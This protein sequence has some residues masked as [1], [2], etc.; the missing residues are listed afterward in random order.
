[1]L[2]VGIESVGMFLHNII[3]PVQLLLF[4]NDIEIWFRLCLVQ[5]MFGSIDDLLIHRVAFMPK[6][7]S[8]I[9]F[10]DVIT[11]LNSKKY[12]KFKFKIQK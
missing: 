11:S 6:T 10:C 4:T 5:V 12:L 3:R 2:Y 1:M 9:H 8:Q 7:L